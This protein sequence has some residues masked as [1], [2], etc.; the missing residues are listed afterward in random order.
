LVNTEKQF[1]NL[2]EH[3]IHQNV[4]EIRATNKADLRPETRGA[5][6]ILRFLKSILC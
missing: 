5:K 1:S 2:A 6:T 3:M 4:P